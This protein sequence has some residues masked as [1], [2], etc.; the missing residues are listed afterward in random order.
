MKELQKILTKEV[1]RIKQKE[2][3]VE[4]YPTGNMITNNFTKPL[5]SSLF[6]KFRNMI[7]GIIGDQDIELY[8]ENYKQPLITF[9]LILESQGPR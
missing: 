5:Q 3:R 2:I 4:H 1:H 8:K 9:G 7:L 6:W